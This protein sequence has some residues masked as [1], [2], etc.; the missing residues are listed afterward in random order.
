MALREIVEEKADR[1]V[2]SSIELTGVNTSKLNPDVVE[3]MQETVWHI[4]QNTGAYYVLCAHKLWELGTNAE[5]EQRRETQGSG[6]NLKSPVQCHSRHAK[7]P[8]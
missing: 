5:A 8:T 6:R 1:D 4:R 3:A 2:Y 7:S